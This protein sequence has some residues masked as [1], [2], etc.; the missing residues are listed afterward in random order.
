MADRKKTTATRSAAPDRS[1][2][3]DVPF[4][5]LAAAY[6]ARRREVDALENRIKALTVNLNLARAELERLVGG[7]PPADA[8]VVKRSALQTAARR[9]AATNRANHARGGD[10]FALLAR[11]AIRQAGRPLTADE[12]RTAVQATGYR[13][14]ATH[15]DWVRNGLFRS[16]KRKQLTRVINRSGVAYELGPKRPAGETAEPVEIESKGK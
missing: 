5:E 12:I 9:A 4:R 6:A 1:R 14:Q 7:D 3:A 10:S 8:V 13:S 2:L 11:A 16:R 15:S